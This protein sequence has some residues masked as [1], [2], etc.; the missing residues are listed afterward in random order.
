MTDMHI[1]LRRVDE[2]FKMEAVNEEG[3]VVVMDGAETIGG[4]GEGMRPMQVLLSSLAGCSTIDVIHIL[5]KQRQQLDHIEVQV[6]GARAQGKVP[7]L[8][9]HIHLHYRLKGPLKAKKVQQA[10]QLSIEK[11][12]SVAKILEP[13]AQIE[14]SF[15]IVD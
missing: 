6:R 1:R 9:T 4:K 3:H 13:T 11:Y 12:C 8:F 10:I 2:A 7:A 14:W 15:E 5:R